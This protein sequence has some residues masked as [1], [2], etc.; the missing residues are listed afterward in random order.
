MS[1]SLCSKNCLQR[2]LRAFPEVATDWGNRAAWTSPGQMYKHS[3]LILIHR[4]SK[5]PHPHCMERDSWLILVLNTPIWRA[6]SKIQGKQKR[7]FRIC[8][9]NFSDH[10]SKMAYV[11][12][13]SL[14]GEVFT[15]GDQLILFT[16]WET[17]NEPSCGKLGS[18]QRIQN[19]RRIFEAKGKLKWL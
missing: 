19:W 12:L 13:L 1:T 16:S 4:D 11:W 5:N 9:F 14:K 6:S 17:L 3:E 18:L 7:F 8:V 10:S 2:D 15:Q